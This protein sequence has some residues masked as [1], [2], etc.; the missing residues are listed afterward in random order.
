V[1]AWAGNDGTAAT[2]GCS[3]CPRN[4]AAEGCSGCHPTLESQPYTQR[5][6]MAKAFW[7]PRTL[8]IT[9]LGHGGQALY[10]ARGRTNSIPNRGRTKSIPNRGRTKSI[11]NRGRTK[12]IPNRG[13]TKSI[14]NRGRTKSIHNMRKCV[15]LSQVNF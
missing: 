3:K 8:I 10:S 12:S 11:F 13:R 2:A 4:T 9:T 15:M 6:I 7:G 5:L 14:P 1:A